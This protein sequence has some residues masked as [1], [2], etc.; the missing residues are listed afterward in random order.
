M[1]EENIIEIKR[2]KD[3][4]KVIDNMQWANI[5]NDGNERL[6]IR[7]YDKL[8]EDSISLDEMRD[9][10]RKM[11]NRKEYSKALSKRLEV[12]FYEETVPIRDYYNVAMCYYRMHNFPGS[13]KYFTIVDAIALDFG[14]DLDLGEYLDKSK[15]KQFIGSKSW[16]LINRFDSKSGIRLS[17]LGSRFFVVSDLSVIFV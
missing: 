15:Q 6:L 10:A 12:I 8:P 7:T 5:N 16:I 13:Y 1:K 11:F 4:I 2:I 3:Y 14:I 9:E 17:F